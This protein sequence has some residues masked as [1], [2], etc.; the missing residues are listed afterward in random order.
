MSFCN[1]SGRGKLMSKLANA[2]KPALSHTLANSA[3][4]RSEY[5]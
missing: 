3:L 1:F 4:L 5:V 2:S